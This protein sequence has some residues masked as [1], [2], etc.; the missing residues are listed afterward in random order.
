[1]ASAIFRQQK[2]LAN[3]EKKI[4]ERFQNAGRDRKMALEVEDKM[5]TVETIHALFDE[6]K[7]CH[8]H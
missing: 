5:R 6:V 2:T 3:L 1:M 7:L 8:N 4:R